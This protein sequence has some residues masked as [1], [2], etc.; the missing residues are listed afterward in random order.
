[1]AES[2]NIPLGGLRSP[3]TSVSKVNKL[4]ESEEDSYQLSNVYD[5]LLDTT[6]VRHV[7]IKKN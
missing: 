7:K 2:Q 3:F 4:Y 6:A 5:R 1:L